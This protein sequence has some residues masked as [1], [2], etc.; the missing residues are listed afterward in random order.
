MPPPASS[1]DLT[2]TGHDD[3]LELLLEVCEDFFTHTN[4]ATRA[5]VDRFLRAHGVTGGPG[6][7]IDMLSLTRRHLQDPAYRDG[8]S[9]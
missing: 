5:E 8:S 4:P 6:W 1:D 9:S 3:L 7:L 2:V